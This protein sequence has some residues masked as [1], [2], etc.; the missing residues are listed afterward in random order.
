MRG[1]EVNCPSHRHGS[2]YTWEDSD[3]GV[4]GRGGL[5]YYARVYRLVFGPHRPPGV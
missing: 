4:G 1:C 2:F 5:T 3:L